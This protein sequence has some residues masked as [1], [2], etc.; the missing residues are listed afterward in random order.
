MAKKEFTVSIPSAEQ[1]S[2]VDAFRI[3][4]GADTDKFVRTGLTPVKAEK[5]DAPYSGECPVVL[6]C[7][8]SQVIVIG[9]YTQYIGKILDVNR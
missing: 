1:M 5:V 3:V 9:T 7:R 6:E 2:H 4:S 8:V